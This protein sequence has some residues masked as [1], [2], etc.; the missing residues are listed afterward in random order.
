M[1]G[2]T[3]ENNSTIKVISPTD[4]SGNYTELV[5][6]E[7]LQKVFSKAEETVG[8]VNLDLS[9]CGY[10]N[11]KVDKN[12]STIKWTKVN[13]LKLPSNVTSIENNA[14]LTFAID[15]LYISK[16]VTNIGTYVMGYPQGNAVFEVSPEN[17][18]YCSVD[19]RVEV[20][21]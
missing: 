6:S 19:E 17:K 20:H 12:F 14:F 2:I 5:S 21:S 18:K 1:S 11:T 4:K 9:A 13:E 3:P 8:K 7:Q 16:D 15:K 10:S